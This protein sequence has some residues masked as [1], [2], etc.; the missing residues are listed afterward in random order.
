MNEKLPNDMTDQMGTTLCVV[1]PPA[2]PPPTLLYPVVPNGFMFFL[3]CEHDDL[4]PLWTSFGCGTSTDRSP[5]LDQCR[6]L[7]N[8][9]ISGTIPSELGN[10]A[11]LFEL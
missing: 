2:P 5:F 10:L 3:K 6:G 9:Q 7:Y 11:S 1:P 8:N 4:V